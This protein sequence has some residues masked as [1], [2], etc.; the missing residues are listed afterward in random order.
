MIIIDMNQISL[1]NVMMNMHMTKSDELE[2]DMIRHM[3]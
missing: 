2:E 1:A 3:N